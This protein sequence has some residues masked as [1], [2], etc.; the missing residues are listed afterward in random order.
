[1]G[2]AAEAL[3]RPGAQRHLLLVLRSA[4]HRR[5]AF[6]ETAFFL[7]LLVS[8]LIGIAICLL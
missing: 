7:A 4:E 3:L 5:G 6:W 1:M 8:G 2:M